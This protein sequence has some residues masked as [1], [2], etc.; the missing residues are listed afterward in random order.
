MPTNLASD[1]GFVLIVVIWTAALLALLT[2]GF[3]RSA[4][5]YVRTAANGVQSARAEALAD[6]GFSLAVLDLMTNRRGN[7]RDG[8]FPTD[9]SVVACAMDRDDLVLVSVQDSGGRINLNLAGEALL[10]AF[11]VGLGSEPQDAARYADTL[12]D[13]R[14]RDNE[15]RAHGAEAPEYRLAGRTY[16][17]KNA[18]F[19]NVEELQQ[20]L[21]FGPDLIASMAPHV[22]IH[23]SSA[24][25]DPKVTR[26]ELADIVSR[27]VARPLPKLQN[28]TGKASVPAE[29]VIS[30]DQRNFLVHAEARLPSGAVYVREAVIELPSNRATAYRLRAWYHGNATSEASGTNLDQLVPAPC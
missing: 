4:Q 28:L 2:L 12:L 8:Q 27:G 10:K 7:A 22:T 23:S 24:G 26:P 25:L 14:D 18:P 16:G 1:R 5:T 6:T 20:V 21:G 19:D 17:P 29:F 30:S 3:T 9:G 11:F 15:R 13:Y